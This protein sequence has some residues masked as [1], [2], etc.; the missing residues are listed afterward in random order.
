MKSI[1]FRQMR[2]VG[3]LPSAGESA[4]PMVYARGLVREYGLETPGFV[5]KPYANPSPQPILY[6]LNPTAGLAQITP[7]RI[8]DQLILF[9]MQNTSKYY[10]IIYY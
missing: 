2:P 3:A 8:I 9:L 5:T 7:P 6:S 10:G 1:K 4:A